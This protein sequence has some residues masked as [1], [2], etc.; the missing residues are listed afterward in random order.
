MKSQLLKLFVCALLNAPAIFCQNAPLPNG[1]HTHDGFFLRITPGFGYT[2]VSETLPDDM[3]PEEYK[4]KDLITFSGF[5]VA[6]TYQIGGTVSEDL[7]IFG[8]SG[9]AFII[10]PTVQVFEEDVETNINYLIL[11]GGVGP[12]ITY[13]FN[14][15]NIYLSA[16][17]LA[18][19]AWVFS[20]VYTTQES[21]IGF[22]FNFMVGKE[23]WAG[24]QWGLGVSL[25]IRYGSQTD[26]DLEDLTI[27]GYSFGALFSATLN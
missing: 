15:A 11:L 1:V 27:S 2:T 9:V 22:G 20:D 18:N 4:G 21:N 5:S 13:Y 14:H 7:I 26:K 8:E 25:Y 3:M 6:N 24:E 12:G 17:V 16:S 19:Y 10:S 23:W